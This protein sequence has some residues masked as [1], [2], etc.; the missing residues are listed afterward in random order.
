MVMD[1]PNSPKVVVISLNDGPM[2]VLKEHLE[3]EDD[4]EEDLELEEQQVNQNINDAKPEAT[5]IS[6]D[7]SEELED[8]FDS[9]YNPSRDH[10]TNLGVDFHQVLSEPAYIWY[11]WLDRCILCSV[12]HCI[13]SVR[14]FRL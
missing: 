6:F 13:Q 8:E 4:P 7:S 11:G 3:A 9:D 10:W 12:W 14:F 1:L 2:E 5:D